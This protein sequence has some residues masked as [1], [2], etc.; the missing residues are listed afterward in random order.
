M[1]KLCI[2]TGMTV[3]GWGGWW[4]GVHVGLLTAFILSS[5]GGGAGVYFGWR[6][7]RDYLE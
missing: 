2:F 5:I 4:A 7:Y 3:L 6:I 1:G